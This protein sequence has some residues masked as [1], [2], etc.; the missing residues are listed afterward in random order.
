MSNSIILYG[1]GSGGRY[2]LKYLRERGEEVSSFA[3]NNPDLQGTDID[4]VK[5][6]SP[7][8]CRGSDIWVCSAISRPAA[9]EIRAH[10]KTLGVKTKPLY[11]CLPVFH[12]NPTPKVQHELIEL[13]ADA[14]SVLTLQDLY[15]FRADP[16]YETQR[17]PSPISELYFPPFISH[18]NDEH[19][20]DLGACSG[21]TIESFLSHWAVFSFITAF[22]P[23]KINYAKLREITHTTR[24]ID[25]PWIETRRNAVGDS[26]EMMAFQQ[27]G[28]YSSHLST[29]VSHPATT[30]VECVKLDDA[31]LRLPPTYIKSDIEGA[32]LEMLWGARNIIKQ[33]SPV[34]AICA[35]HNSEHTWRIPLL[36]HAINPTYKLFLRRYAEG[37]FELVW[38]AV[39]PERVLTPFSNESYSDNHTG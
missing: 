33:C 19:Y 11:E 31:F 5:V 20:C 37:A 2:C 28:D 9:T 24:D 12:E 16:N 1:A 21:D 15:S 10:I 39:P 32:E 34:L 22:E 3:D 13:A 18:R 38:Y 29:H 23:D 25:S 4:G 8:E 17:D 35:Y 36:I 30:M 27:N 14:D 6:R 7:R 26:R